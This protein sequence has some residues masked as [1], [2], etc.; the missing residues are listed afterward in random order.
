[1]EYQKVIINFK[2]Q[3]FILFWIHSIYKSIKKFVLTADSVLT[4]ANF[5]RNFKT[6]SKSYIYIQDTLISGLWLQFPSLMDIYKIA[7]SAILLCKYLILL[8]AYQKTCTTMSFATRYFNTWLFIC[9]SSL[10][11]KKS[12]QGTLREEIFCS[13]ELLILTIPVDFNYKSFFLWRYIMLL[14][15]EKYRNIYI[16]DGWPIKSLICWRNNC[17]YFQKLR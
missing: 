9:S 3:S 1:M 17:I 2:G 7:Y 8:N 10:Y 5:F 14:L 16:L 6:K 13:L 11:Y 4:T 12:I 15:K